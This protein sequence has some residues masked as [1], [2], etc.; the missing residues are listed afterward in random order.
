MQKLSL[1]LLSTLLFEAYG[2]TPSFYVPGLK[3]NR[4]YEKLEC[5]SVANEFKP[6][7]AN[8]NQLK[9]DIKKNANCQPVYDQVARYG[10]QIE[11]G[12]EKFLKLTKENKDKVLSA[13]DTTFIKNYAEQSTQYAFTLLDMVTGRSSCF[14][15]NRKGEGFLFASTLIHE[16][17]SLASAVAGPYGAPIS[18]VGN[19]ISGFFTGI[20]AISQN[21]AGYKFDDPESRQ[22]YVENLCTYYSMQEELNNL[23]YPR[24]R[25]ENLETIA[26]AVNE[27]LAEV[28]ED[29]T[30][31]NQ[32][33]SFLD[34]EEYVSNFGT[35]KNQNNLVNMIYRL[36]ENVN[37]SSDNFIGSYIIDTYNNKRW[38][39]EELSSF[40]RN[41]NQIISNIG[42]DILMDQ[43]LG[44]EKFLL[45]R[46]TPK[47][48]K[49]QL[50]KAR[51][52]YRDLMSYYHNEFSRL[53]YMYDYRVK[54]KEDPSYRPAY[55]A[56]FQ[57]FEQVQLGLERHEE[58]IDNDSLPYEDRILLE[59]HYNKFINLYDSSY[60]AFGV[61]NSFCNFFKEAKI[62]NFSINNA[63]SNPKAKDL[64]DNLRAATPAARPYNFQNNNGNKNRGEFSTWGESIAD[65]IELLQA[66]N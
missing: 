6:M 43:K 53:T 3:S 61:Y 51:D 27:H 1:I 32:L 46:E 12:R 62:F 65:T 64:S 40:D 31:C 20:H 44:I 16:V 38:L 52:S 25:R 56:A 15:R 26:V 24:Q 11:Q 35:E 49:F 42:Q 10:D 37:E 45:E 5:P 36:E 2:I 41:S 14:E 17:T 33:L 29:C 23:L 48:L 55:G 54:I 7:I 4:D 30:D 28:V 66:R 47:F 8:L 39:E 19:L 58:L 22:Q 21:R 9:V 34:Q 50:D 57:Y 63:C 59:S 13:N 60:I 18:V